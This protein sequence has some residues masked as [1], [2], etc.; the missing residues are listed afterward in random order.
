MPQQQ[1]TDLPEQ[2]NGYWSCEFPDWACECGHTPGTCEYCTY[3]R[4]EKLIPPQK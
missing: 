4:D 3:I 1:K 2:A